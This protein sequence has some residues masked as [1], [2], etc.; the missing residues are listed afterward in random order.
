M[1]HGGLGTST[2]APGATES[3]DAFHD[4]TFTGAGFAASGGDIVVTV[5]VAGGRITNVE[6]TYPD[7]ADMS[8][9]INREHVPELIEST[10][11]AQSANIS[12]I[13]G[14]TV[15]STAFRNSLQDA[16]NQSLAGTGSANAGV[17]VPPVATVPA[18]AGNLHD[19]V[20]FGEGFE[21]G[22][23]GNT[24]VAMT[25]IDGKIAG[26]SATY[27]IGNAESAGISAGAIPTL[28][29]EAKEAQSADIDVITGAT[30]TSNA[31]KQSLQNAINQATHGAPVVAPLGAVADG[32]FVGNPAS[33]G[34]AGDAVATIHVSGGRITE[35][36]GE[37]PD[38][39]WGDGL[40]NATVIP[41]II[42][43]A[44]E[45]QTAGVDNVTGAT[46]SSTAF[47]ASLQS[48]INAARGGEAAAP[49][50][51][52]ALHDG[53]FFGEGFESG[54][55]GNT[56]VTMT[57]HDGHIVGISATYPIGN[58][59]SAGISAGA[60]PTLVTEAKD[61]QSADIDV[62]TGATNTSNAFKQ[63][64][65]DAINQSHTAASTAAPLGNLTDGT[66]TGN[67]ASTGRAGDGAVTIT[68]AG[69]HITE[70]TSDFPEHEWGDGHSNASVAEALTAEVKEAQSS[71]VNFIT[72]ATNSSTAFIASLQSAINQAR[73]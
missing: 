36:T 70:I 33:T 5:T 20:F 67:P 55:G 60:V 69:G 65:Q 45:R 15:S 4:G 8:G 41:Q 29:T 40:S 43:Q 53:V 38:H 24:Y 73:G 66:F 62:V 34:R 21:S 25:V 48:A 46:G 3:A 23:G 37:Y 42:S 32:T 7:E 52:A 11:A 35:I 10:I 68:V 51:A 6:A 14:A 54:P 30:N 16:L 71:H 13:T 50:A 63:S 2:P 17:A 44:V 27:P 59:E 9:D 61:S 31:F 28:V 56:Y 57:V 22:P 26:I 58:A 64:L 1:A 12:N 19:G 39:D 47:K 18:P 72:G 49:P